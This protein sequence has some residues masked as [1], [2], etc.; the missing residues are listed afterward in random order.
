MWCIP[1]LRERQ[2]HETIMDLEDRQNLEYGHEGSGYGFGD[3][4]GS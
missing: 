2:F 1:E 4:R 3:V